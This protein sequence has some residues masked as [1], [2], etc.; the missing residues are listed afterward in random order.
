MLAKTKCP[1]QLESAPLNLC[2][3]ARDPALQRLAYQ[4]NGQSMAVGGA[5][6]SDRLPSA[7]HLWVAGYAAK[8]LD[9]AIPLR[10]S[11]ACHGHALR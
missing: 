6:A 7:N 5:L 4:L 10:S 11:F 1:G 9:Q 8:T 3:S 2:M